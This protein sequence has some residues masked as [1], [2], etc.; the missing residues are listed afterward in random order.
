MTKVFSPHLLAKWKTNRYREINCK[1]GDTVKKNYFEKRKPRKQ[2]IKSGCWLSH[3]RLRFLYNMLIQFVFTV[4]ILTPY[5]TGLP[6]ILL[7]EV[8]KFPL[9]KRQKNKQHNRKALLFSWFSYTDSWHISRPVQLYGKV[10]L[11]SLYV[12]VPTCIKIR[13]QK[14]A[15][16]NQLYWKAR[17]VD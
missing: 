9:D 3:H 12:R 17:A 4:T 14:Q 13:Q 10:L 7:T 16:Y 8:L 6:R 1:L 5:F 11:T 2:Y 15:S